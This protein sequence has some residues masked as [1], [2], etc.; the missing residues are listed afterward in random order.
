MHFDAEWTTAI[1]GLIMTSCS[2]SWLRFRRRFI[3]T[4]YTGSN[5]RN[6]WAHCW[7]SI[8]KALPTRRDDITHRMLDVV[9]VMGFWSSFTSSNGSHYLLHRDS[10]T[11][12][13]DL[14]VE[15]LSLSLSLPFDAGDLY[16]GVCAHE[17]WAICWISIW[18]GPADVDMV[19][20]VYLTAVFVFWR[21]T[22][23]I[24]VSFHLICN[25]CRISKVSQFILV[26]RNSWPRICVQ[27]L[28]VPSWCN[29]ILYTC[30]GWIKNAT[31]PCVDVANFR[32]KFSYSIKSDVLMLLING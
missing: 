13:S 22:I 23:D 11:T 19:K 26:I 6:N 14:L 16:A 18:A 28:G 1:G 4:T 3:F 2:H 32:T 24:L 31:F 21:P 17:I 30:Y 27:L 15:D 10:A 20:T 25:S 9:A 8:L 7:L 12:T 5:A 29:C